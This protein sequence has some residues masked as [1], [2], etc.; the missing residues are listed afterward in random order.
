[1]TLAK[2][3]V[4]LGLNAR[5]FNAGIAQAMGQLRAFQGSMKGLSGQALSN[6]GRGLTYGLTIPILAA[7]AGIALAGSQLTSE[8]ARVQSV[9]ATPGNN[10]TAQIAQWTNEVQAL[11]VELG[12][13][14][15]EVSSGLY[16]IVS[17]FGNLSNATEFLRIAGRAAV[18]GQSDIATS[19]K[20][21]V[22]ATRAWGD[23]STE[24]V[25]RMADLA[26]ATVRVGTLTESELGPA[27]AGLLPIMKL[28]NVRLEEGFAGLASLA[29]VS[30][31]ASQASTQLQRA[32]T[33][34]VA[35]NTAL[36]K[37]MKQTGTESLALILQN[38]GLIAAFRKVN[39]ISRDTG[40]PLQKLL[41]RIEALKAIAT[42]TGPQL[43]AFNDNLTAMGNAAG[44]VDRAFAGATGGISNVEFQWK[45]AV[46]R[47]RIIGEDLYQAFGPAAV[48]V[49]E[50][51]APIGRG[52]EVMAQAV[53]A[54][55]TGTL[56]GI[57]WA[58]LGLVALGPVVSIVGGL[59]T[60]FSG[61]STVLM[62]VNP[63][64]LAVA[65]AGGAL[66]LAWA[67]D[68]GGIQGGVRDFLDTIERR[69]KNVAEAIE[70]LQ[71]TW[72]A[73]R[74]PPDPGESAQVR[75]FRDVIRAAG[76]AVVAIGPVRSELS[77]FE[78]QMIDSAPKAQSAW[79]LFWGGFADNMPNFSQMGADIGALWS[80][81]TSG[82]AA[83]GA[84]VTS[85]INGP[86]QGIGPVFE[87]MS[88]TATTQMG[89]IPQSAKG[90]AS[91]TK[92]AFTGVGWGSVG[93]GII[94]GIVGG[95][96]GAAS[97]LATAAANAAKAAL[98]AAKGA[99]GINSPSTVFRTQVGLPIMQ[100]WA[101]GI[102]DGA[103]RVNQAINNLIGDHAAGGGLAVRVG[104]GYGMTFA[105]AGGGDTHTTIEITF[106]DIIV[107]GGS[108]KAGTV[109]AESITD[110]LKRRGWL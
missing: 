35:P 82:A 81:I 31:G 6:V 56:T 67:N 2:L 40:I 49:A 65:A 24:A 62:A 48:N 68:W 30:G 75:T 78:Q 99:L 69:A 86:V 38:E 9:I 22:L 55:D 95:I 101:L 108:A 92:S 91:S 54:M 109:V 45:Q 87:S 83:A 13:T 90:A 19:T 80:S 51:L 106:G 10:G 41:G 96:K 25:Q 102:N 105:G 7:A 33:S 103:N 89:K 98:N 52:L 107:N 72:D 88:S 66:W 12:R 44:D 46:Q 29:G 20:N 8:M 58:L 37:A 110:A 4:I 73:F 64:V 50:S 16:E 76:D 85:G 59:T 57:V 47:L 27:M 84:G 61:L 26:S 79:D 21:L 11:G 32:I 1:M 42:L 39:E 63:W 71:R 53:A 77:H 60:I 28:Y 34:L 17:A 93:S 23:S 18:A 15:P 43:E 5:G 70:H 74:N 97:S 14:S 3:M 94:S 104:A 36:Q 100:G